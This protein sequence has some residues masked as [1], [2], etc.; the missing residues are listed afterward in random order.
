MFNF[1]V[2]LSHCAFVLKILASLRPSA[3]ALNSLS[4][5]FSCNLELTTCN[6]FCISADHSRVAA[7][8]TCQIVGG[9]HTGDIRCTGDHSRANRHAKM[10]IRRITPSLPPAISADIMHFVQFL[11][12]TKNQILNAIFHVLIHNR[13]QHRLIHA[14]A[15]HAF[16]INHNIWPRPTHTQAVRDL[17]FNGL[18]ILVAVN[19]IH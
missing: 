6:Y 3:F 9:G 19:R 5:Y 18:W 10:P 1:S 12:R 11:H 8:T 2:S 14:I 16:G 4:S 13:I 15:A 7:T 17:Q